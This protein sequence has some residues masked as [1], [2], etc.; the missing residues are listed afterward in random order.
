[1]PVSSW[2]VL[3]NSFLVAYDPRRG[4]EWAEWAQGPQAQEWWTWCDVYLS[5]SRPVRESTL[6]P[7]GYYLI[8]PP[9]YYSTP[10]WLPLFSLLITTRY[11]PTPSW[12]PSLFP[13]GYYTNPSWLLHYPLLV[14]FLPSPG[15]HPFPSWLQ[16]YLLLVTTHSPPGYNPIPSPN[17]NNEHMQLL[18]SIQYITVVSIIRQL[19]YQPPDNYCN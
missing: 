8:L 3:G 11:Y 13:P 14:T 5:N 2:G 10:S 7:P 4:R 1:M 12:L 19:L 17:Y 6:L 18:Y 16:P 15:Y 9:G